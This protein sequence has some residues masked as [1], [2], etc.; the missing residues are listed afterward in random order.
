MAKRAV[1]LEFE[2]IGEAMSRL[3]KINE[4]IRITSAQRIVGM[5]NRV[6]HGYDMIDDG[7]IWGTLKKHLPLLKKEIQTELER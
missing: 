7:I 1:E 5:R 4:D 2:I 6:I 3:L